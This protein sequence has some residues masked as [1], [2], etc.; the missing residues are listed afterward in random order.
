MSTPT[1]TTDDAQTTDLQTLECLAFELMN[2][3]AGEDRE[4]SRELWQQKSEVRTEWR[5]RAKRLLSSVTDN[6]LR[7]RAGDRRALGRQL[8]WLVTIPPRPAYS[9]ESESRSAES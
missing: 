1:D 4:A 9:L 5:A 6:G 7:L 8:D 3:E 2:L